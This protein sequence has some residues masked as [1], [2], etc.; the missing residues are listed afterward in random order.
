MI[1]EIRKK[2]IE[3]NPE[4]VK[5]EFGCDVEDGGNDCQYEHK[6][7]SG[8]IVRINEVPN[9]WK[10]YILDNGKE[11]NEEDFSC[12][13]KIIGRPIRLE[14]IIFTFMKVLFDGNQFDAMGRKEIHDLLRLGRFG[15]SLEEQS[16]QCLTFIAHKFAL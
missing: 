1:E 16:E 9:L 10:Y 11:I 3:A 7:P 5:L 15:V 13:G 14:D 6:I 4:I 12:C 2:C 8:T